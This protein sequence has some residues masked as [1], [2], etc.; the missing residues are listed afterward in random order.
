MASTVI[1]ALRV[2]FSADSAAFENATKRVRSNATLT[3]RSMGTAKAAVTGFFSAFSIGVLATITKR[4]LDFA[5]SLGETAQQL[6]VTTRQLQIYRFAAGQV[7]ISQEQMDKGLEKLNISLGKAKLGA[8]APKKAF[9]VLSKL[10]GQD[11]VASSKQGGDALPLVADGLAKIA[12]RSKRAGI[13]TAIFSKAGSQLDTLLSGGSAAINELA[14][15]ADR[16]GIV[17]S[18]EQIKNADDT[19][20]KLEAVKTVLSAQI[21]GVVAQNAKSILGLANSLA[22]LTGQI[23]RF[24][25]SNPQLALGIMGAMLGGRVGGLPGAV[26]GGVGGAILGGRMAQNANDQNN[27]LPFRMQAVRD[28]KK[29]F[30][31][32]KATPSGGAGFGGAGGIPISAGSGGNVRA[33]ETEL[34]RQTALLVQATAAFNASKQGGGTVPTV[35]V[36]QFL[37]GGGGGGR[38]KK[39]RSAEEAQRLA[40]QQLRDAYQFNQDMQRNQMDVLQGQ[41]DLATTIDGR[42]VLDLQMLDLERDAYKAQLAY[43]VATTDG[44]K[45]EAEAR[46]KSLLAE[47]DKADALKRQAIKEDAITQKREQAAHL[48]DTQYD[49]QLEL[50]SLE[51]NLADTAKERRA[52]ELRIL[53]IS[54]QREE[55]A[56]KELAASKDA[57]TA[58]EAR[59]RLA[60]LPQ[61]YEAQRENVMA[62][63]RGPMEEWQHQFSDISDELQQLKVNGIEGAVDA[64][65]HLT[66]GWKS[67]RDAAISAIKD[68]IAQLIRLQLM[69]LAA[70]IVG[71]AAGGMGGG[72][73]SFAPQG[74][75]AGLAGAGSA[76]MSLNL[77]AGLGVTGVLGFAHGGS[78]VFGGKFGTDRNLL[79]M[80]GMPIA[81]VSRGEPWSFGHDDSG[82]GRGRGGDSFN[83][84]V[85]VIGG[86]ND[87]H[88]TG[89]Q[90]GRTAARQI[91]RYARRRG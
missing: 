11:I 16:L 2:I 7:G 71:T 4:A 18:D 90:V 43:D 50:A 37:A 5:G 87:G 62:G 14:K 26:L 40:E 3:A 66:E 31:D 55:A 61:K 30:E 69:K 72:F 27:D 52:A 67:F 73:G 53:D 89:F 17:L 65:T 83:V 49:I 84:P 75:S 74:I 41:R 38:S 42:A 77:G 68:V 25:N 33:A 51:A 12:D 58:V 1:G 44:N 60:A 9:E 29:K 56:L 91:G 54:R 39:D 10:I 45:A 35:D 81:R 63:T 59:A 57:A 24:L 76:P 15:A 8:E 79:S 22:A 13:E 34:R 48:V 32:A 80:N 36:P 6:G 88:R 28:A 82:G 64:L 20:D 85:T 46:A 86:G 21:A 70:N 78:G 19:A 47:Y 23:I